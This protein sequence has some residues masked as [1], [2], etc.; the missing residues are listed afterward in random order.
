MRPISIGFPGGMVK[1][2]MW[3][4]TADEQTFPVKSL[5]RGKP[6][7]EAY[8]IKYHLTEDEVNFIRACLGVKK[9]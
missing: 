9:G 3:E 5:R 4:G 1:M 6:Y 2:T 8:G 7:V